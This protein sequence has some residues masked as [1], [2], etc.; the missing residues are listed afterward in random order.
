MVTGDV[1]AYV[2]TLSAVVDE[3]IVVRLLAHVEEVAC[4]CGTVV[5]WGIPSDFDADHLSLI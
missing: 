1:A 3:F 2:A 4:D 5:C